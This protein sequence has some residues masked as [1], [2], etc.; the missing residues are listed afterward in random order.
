M[1]RLSVKLAVLL[2]LAFAAPAWAEQDAVR[3]EVGKPLQSAQELIKGKKYRDALEKLHE[4]DQITGKSPYEVS[5]VEQLRLIVAAGSGDGAAALKAYEAWQATGRLSPADQLRYL[6]AVANTFYQ[7]KDYAN[8]AQWAKR[9]FSEGGQ[10]PQVSTL[11]IQSYYLGGDYAATAK[12]VQDILKKDDHPSE[13]HLQLLA[14]SYQKL[15][16]TANYSATLEKLVAF[17]PKP[18]YWADLIHRIVTRPGFADRLSLDVGRLEQALG[19]LKTT[20]QYVDHA[21]LALQAGLPA[22]AKQVLDQG[23]AKG[24]LGAGPDA[25]RHRRLKELAQTNAAKDLAGLAKEEADA[26]AAKDG[27][28]LVAAGLN[29]L[30]NNQPEKA[31]QLIEKGLEKGG[32]KHPEDARLHL[33]I[34]L[35]KAGQ[36]SKAV[37]V[38][39]AVQG[40]DGTAD[41]ARLW[42]AQSGRV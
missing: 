42:V 24:V 35:V 20:E 16:D 4:A 25:D 32:L 36:K 9:Y 30:V 14:S 8:A 26:L 11:L 33:G 1:N 7:N 6:S 23:F 18:E 34:A 27:N 22:E 37:D 39:H 15:N 13:T 3:S 19:N 41:L 31:A 21:E 28:A 17:Y 38:F 29:Y 12:A 5:L 40:S 2:G 10:D